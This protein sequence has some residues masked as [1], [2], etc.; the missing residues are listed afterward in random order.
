M[1]RQTREGETI[2]ELNYQRKILLTDVF[3]KHIAKIDPA[4]KRRIEWLEQYESG[5]RWLDRIVKETR[6]HET[7]LLQFKR[8]C[9]HVQK[10]PDELMKMYVTAQIEFLQHQTPNFVIQDLMKM[11]IPNIK[12]SNGNPISPET[13]R[14]TEIAISS[15][16]RANG[17]ELHYTFQVTKPRVKGL[18]TPSELD[19]MLQAKMSFPK[20]FDADLYNIRNKALIAFFASTGFRPETVS[21]L[22]WEDLKSTGLKNAPIVIVVDPRRMK[23]KMA[24]Q[25]YTFTYQTSFIHEKANSILEEYKAKIN[26]SLGE[27]L[28]RRYPDTKATGRLDPMS[29][30]EIFRDVSFACWK[31]KKRY[32]P[33]SFRH[34]VSNAYTFANIPDN[35]ILLLTG[36]AL[37]NILK[38][39][40]NVDPNNPIQHPKIVDLLKKFITAISYLT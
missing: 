32:T 26:P 19:E 13:K 27:P 34:F 16:F 28:F 11:E 39:Y 15:F 36:H 21:L 10:T 24:S 7:Y 17:H 9:D 38:F 23:G 22:K 14:Q 2:A 12:M 33:N 37:P 29:M 3:Q 8:F 1:V 35:D 40:V 5:K 31:G 25:R 18:P 20:R 4:M 30:W 6:T